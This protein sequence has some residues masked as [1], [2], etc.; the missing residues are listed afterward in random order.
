MMTS[1]TKS[2]LLDMR[3][4][5]MAKALDE[6]DERGPVAELSFHERL[7][8]LVDREHLMR[9]E[10]R[11]ARR[12][13]RARLKQ[14]ACV[15]DI[16]YRHARSLD[17]RVFQELT[18]CR[19]IHAKRNVIIT[20]ATGLGKTWL[21]CALADKACREGFST[22]YARVPR[23]VEELAAAR[24]DGTYLK[25]LSRIEKIDL[26]VL[27]DWGIAPLQGQAQQDILEVVDDRAGIRS[28]LVTSQLPVN[29]WHDTI[30]DP[31]VADALLDRII[32]KATKIQLK[33]P[34]MR[35]HDVSGDDE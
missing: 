34:T 1:Q 2:K 27:D 33:G 35:E 9:E 22:L 11:T 26:L 19:W 13:Q 18:T 17:K 4:F 32:G 25:T 15:E 16:N 24:V 7:A 8:L 14:A 10:R 3:L 5:G 29:K 20:G 31:T 23:L 6:Q 28:T 30:S 21:S 12:L